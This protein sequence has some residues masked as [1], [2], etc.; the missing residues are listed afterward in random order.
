[1]QYCRVYARLQSDVRKVREVSQFLVGFLNAPPPK[2][3]LIDC[4]IACL[5]ACSVVAGLSSDAPPP[6]WLH[7]M[8]ASTDVANMRTFVL[9]RM[10]ADYSKASLRELYLNVSS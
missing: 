6:P 3:G 1:M 8:A 4:L 7:V 5:I 10:E 9:G 2:C